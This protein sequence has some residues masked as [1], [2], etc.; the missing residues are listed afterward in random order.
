[1]LPR[2]LLASTFAAAK[3]RLG[4][5]GLVELLGVMGY[6]GLVSM[7]VNTDRYSLPPG[8][9]PELKPLE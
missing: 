5:R 8:V 6:Y 4:E 3:E 1:M 7:V 2:L 9:A